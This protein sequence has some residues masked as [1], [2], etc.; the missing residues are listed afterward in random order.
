MKHNPGNCVAERA[1]PASLS[2]G[3]QVGKGLFSFLKGGKKKRLVKPNVNSDVLA[4]AELA[5]PRAAGGAAETSG[6]R[7]S[8]GY[9]VH[10]QSPTP[11]W[12]CRDSWCPW[13][14][15]PKGSSHVPL[16][17]DL[18]LEMGQGGKILV[19]LVIQTCT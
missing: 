13:M 9:G 15:Q 11:S 14:P 18:A 4:A 6:P 17:L 8:P 2:G 19:F 7:P 12:M 1:K 10:V 3:C 16:L 5:G